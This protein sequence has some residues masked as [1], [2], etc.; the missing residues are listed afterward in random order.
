M[1]ITV[2]KAI[3]DLLFVRDTVVV[4]G[5]GAFVKKPISAQVNPEGNHLA[6]PSC[7]ISFDANLREDND[8]IINYMS[9]K[10][11]MGEDEA[12]SLLTQFVSD[13]FKALK[14]EKKMEL[15]AIGVLRYDDGN[16][17]VFEPSEAVNY[18]ADAFGL[19]GLSAKPIPQVKAKEVRQ[20]KSQPQKSQPQKVQPHNDEEDDYLRHRRG[21]PWIVLGVLLVAVL[22]YELFYFRIN[23]HYGQHESLPPQ[24]V[25]PV[26]VVKPDSLPV[27]TTDSVAKE[28]ET[29]DSLVAVPE[30]NIKIIA[31][32]YNK[33]IHAEKMVNTLKNDGFPNAFYEPRGKNWFVSF[34]RYRTDEEA[35]A[36]LR[37]IKTK[38]AY[39]AWILK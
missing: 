4:P 14:T 6:P 1:M 15:E 30:G 25:K 8:L 35:K 37:E 3:S 26:E 23:D 19:S 7:E 33:E 38:T 11:N 21:W 10:G 31:G 27:V 17:L 9:K 13:C 39:K 16:N 32:S 36:A 12:R 20:Q 2:T 29:K 24:I 18:N 34:G 28:P 22:I 5:L